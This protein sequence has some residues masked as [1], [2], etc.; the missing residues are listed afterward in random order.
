MAKINWITPAGEIGTYPENTEVSIQLETSSTTANYVLLAGALPAGLQLTPQGRLYGFPQVNTIGNPT[1]RGYRFTVRASDLPDVADRTFTIVINNIVP[2]VILKYGVRGS[3]VPSTQGN[4]NV[5]WFDRG[6]GYTT[7]GISVQLSDPPLGGEKPILGKV[8][9]F[10][11]GAINAVSLKNPGSGYINPPSIS[12]FGS[13]SWAAVGSV[14]GVEPLGLEDLGKYFDG[15]PVNLQI[16]TLQVSP[17]GRLDWQVVRGSLPPGLRLTQA[18]LITGFALAPAQAGEVGT[19]AYDTGRYDQFVYDFEGAAASRVYQFTVRIFD[20]I[21][22]TDQRYRIGIYAKSFFRNDNILITADNTLYTADKDG[23]E[24]PSITT[25]VRTLPSVRQGQSYAYKLD[26]YY[27][28]PT[29]KIKWRVNSGGPAGF[30]QGAAPNPDSNNNYF[31]L[32]PFDGKS[33]D[34][35]DLKLPT[36]IYMDL[37]TG[38]LLG[39]IG[40]VTLPESTFEFDAI[41]YVEQTLTNN[42]VARRESVP[43]RFNIKVLSDVK[44][45]VVW[46]TG[47][48]LGT[49]IN[50]EVSTLEIQ[51]TTTKN[52]S[53]TY[54]VKS[55]Q[56]LRIPQGLAILD[57]GLVVGRT[58]FDFY[59]LDRKNS[60]ITFDKT[61]NTY[62]SFYQFTIIA[63]DAT[64]TVYD[65][66]EFTLKISNI[67][68][69]PYE[70]LYLKALLP[71][72]LRR[73]FRSIVT[74]PNLSGADLIYRVN[75]PYFGVQDNLT[76]LAQVGINADT[77]ANYVASMANYHYDKQINF[78]TIKK[79][80]ARNVDGTTKYEVLY[81]EVF[82]YNTKNQLAAPAI[83]EQYL[84][85]YGTL[86]DSGSLFTNDNGAITDAVT[87]VD[88]FGTFIATH[89]TGAP[90]Y[91]NSFANMSHEIEQG[92]G[93]QY[94]GA[95]PLWMKSVQPGTGSPLGFTRALVLAY[96]KPGLG[97]KLLYRYRSSLTTI[98]Y[99]VTDV[100]NTFKFVADRY[101]W[102]RTLS[103]NYDSVTGKFVSSRNTSFDLVP[104]FGIVDK[105]AW[106][107]RESRT[108]DSI[109]SVAY[110][111]TYGYLAVG[112]GTSIFNSISGEN[113]N[114]ETQLIGLTYTSALTTATVADNTLLKFPYMS[115]LSVGDELLRNSSFASNSRSYI[116][117]L[118]YYTRLTS[119]VA[120]TIPAGTQLE[121]FSPQD[122][123]RSFANVSALTGIGSS[124]IYLDSVSALVPGARVFVRGIDVANAC[125][126][127]GTIGSTANL[128]IATTNLIPTGTSIRFDDLTGNVIILSTTAATPAGSQQIT[129]AS[130]GNVKSG[131]YPSIN[132]LQ[133]GTQIGSKF[134]DATISSAPYPTSIPAGIDLT[135]QHRITGTSS[136]G[137]NVLYI[138]NTDKISVGTEVFSTS[139]ETNTSA[140]AN[141]AAMAAGTVTYVTVPTASIN[142]V[143]FPGMKITGPGL[144]LDS[145]VSAITTSG[146]GSNLT[147]AY[148]YTTLVSQQTNVAISLISPTTIYSG[149][150]VIGKTKSTLILSD[151][152][153]TSIAPGADQTISFGLT[154]IPLNKVIFDGDNWIAVGN[155]GLVISRPATSRAWTQRFGLVYGDLKS[156]AS[157]TE[158]TAAGKNKTYI[159][160]GTEGII[161]RSTDIDTWSVPII[162]GANETVNGVAY[163]NGVWIAVGDAGQILTSTNNGLNWTVDR[164][165]TSLDLYDIG[166]WGKWIIVGNNGNVWTREDGQLAWTNYSV[167]TADSLR[168]VG[169][170]NSEFI[171]VGNRG[172]IATSLDGTSWRYSD[173]FTTSILNGITS[174][175]TTPVAVGTGGTILTQSATYTVDWAIRNISFEEFN[176][177]N[178]DV[179][180]L[181][182]YRVAAGDTLIF[183][184]QEG[185]GRS[186]DGWNQYPTP[187]G[188][189][190][191]A[192]LDSLY[193]QA[194]TIPGY[195]EGLNNPLVANQRGGIWQV[196][197]DEYN[198]ISLTFV[199][200]V[201]LGQVVS[202]KNDIAQ[203]V[204]GPQIST[205]KTVPEYNTLQQTVH[206][207]NQNTTFDGTGTRFSTNRDNYNEPGTLDKY[208]KFPK[209]GVFE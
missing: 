79:A 114:N 197:I 31:T 40:V 131:F 98:G 55:G 154:S 104:T 151:S 119:T 161:V 180:G 51:A 84:T 4:I 107:S 189:L 142:G 106:I 164:N 116:T 49:I 149:T 112:A 205:G 171:V 18:G 65:E 185:F 158:I 32:V 163:S 162:S 54:K 169:Y 73:V 1:S 29:T 128:N 61:T 147:I 88:S 111:A 2:P 21:N 193:D 25:S 47:T 12:F 30:D 17:T 130:L 37:D 64:G 35:A 207:S 23:N 97:D 86:S 82:D 175:A 87:G 9:L 94:Q 176:N 39:N 10:A 8:Y 67:N 56:Y 206:N 184:Q 34:Q 74:N 100:M 134:V 157:R 105:G 137:T 72:A 66:R 196:A 96:A 141:I 122:G 187:F 89:Y 144:P 27:F 77:A 126:V 108:T 145:V 209:T 70:N 194:T 199:R 133:S 124:T 11:N 5:D 69:K 148:A 125:I 75:D 191:L 41:A 7:N 102:D 198:T 103:V 140:T 19:A 113:W 117:S 58:S 178:I 93:Y 160:V 195:K 99:G 71:S 81:V 109:N 170:A 201:N 150:K 203:L 60:E 45:V 167:G 63:Q 110:S 200:Q 68:T 121:L 101:Q 153:L 76:M 15:D 28:N 6:R 118:A 44:D 36:G 188:Q 115:E 182:G 179:V 208:L 183:A 50:G 33:F 143:V 120:N 85:S 13:N 204:Y 159:A 59:S 172:A 152:L 3:V 83:E 90:V 174:D 186:N 22:H 16:N 127:N 136:Q 46:T 173:K 91:S 177:V 166:Y 80:V 43:I 53:L 57:D 135:F 92:I 132:S 38:W 190:D 42:T 192:G 78:G 156:I 155:R 95:L 52:T 168:S 26:A 62:D 165:T 14:A 20:G 48:D 123:T 139:A 146:T 138:S 181:K 24:Y 129:F 202:V